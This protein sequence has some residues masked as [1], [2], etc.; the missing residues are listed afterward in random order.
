MNLPSRFDFVDL[1]SGIGGFHIALSELGGNSLGFS[2]INSDAINVY[3]KNHEI[4]KEKN[5]GDITKIKNLP[6]HDLLVAGVP[7]Q[8]WSI[9]GKNLGFEDDRGQLWNDTIYLLSQSKPKAFIF[10]NV[11]GLADPRNRESLR[12]IMERIKEAG[13]HADFYLINSYD[14]GVLQNRV[15]VFIIGFREKKYFKKFKIAN[16]VPNHQKLYEILDDIEKPDERL[17]KLVPKDQ[18]G[19]DIQLNKTRLQKSNGLNHFFIFSDIRNGH[20]TI[21]SWDIFKTTEREKEICLLLLK[22]RR[23]KL[24]GNLDGNPLSYSQF[25][26]LDNSIKEKELK[27]LVKKGI[28]KE[29]NYIFKVNEDGRDLDEKEQYLIDLAKNG[30]L[31]L[32]EIKQ[33]QILKIKKVHIKNS[34][35]KLL[36][37]KKIAC[38]EKR[39]EFKFTRISSGILGINRVYLPSS[40]VYPTLVASDTNDFVAT[41]NIHSKTTQSYKKIFIEKIY[42]TNSYRKITK[43]EACILQGFPKD[44]DLPNSRSRWM[45]LI[46][47]SVAIPVIKSLADSILKTEVFENSK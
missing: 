21:H 20:S 23:K 3:C 38:I 7:C 42:K 47:N 31:R 46:G 35:A 25:K 40:D 22:N 37:D 1:F 33:A 8:S 30:T 45:K 16:P 19:N 26:K 15:R 2:E 41:K 39:Y 4:P 36:E 11:K 24:Y 29:V 12:Y 43:E 9:A 17:A 27:T 6:K 10:E 13:Y 5:F 34:L 28:L 32:D 44:F 14:F 18:F